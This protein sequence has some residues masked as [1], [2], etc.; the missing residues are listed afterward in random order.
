[1][2][3]WLVALVALVA[4]PAAAQEPTATMGVGGPSFC[5]NDL[6][7]VTT[8]RIEWCSDAA[9]VLNIYDTANPA[10]TPVATILWT[11]WTPE[12][13]PEGTPGG[14]CWSADVALDVET[15]IL[16]DACGE[17]PPPLC[18]PKEYIAQDCYIGDGTS[19]RVIPVGFTPDVVAVQ[20]ATGPGG[21]NRGQLVWVRGMDWAEISLSLGG[22]QVFSQTGILGPVADGFRVDNDLNVNEAGARY[23]WFAFAGAE[24]GF[25]AGRYIGSWQPE[26]PLPIDWK[27]DVV[28]II[29]QSTSGWLLSTITVDR[30]ELV[31]STAI[32]GGV[33]TT[34]AVPLVAFD[35]DG[36]R[37]QSCAVGAE[38]SSFYRPNVYGMEYW[39]FA[40]RAIPDAMSV[41]LT[42]G[43]SQARQG[44]PLGCTSKFFWLFRSHVGGGSGGCKLW[45]YQGITAD[46]F[47]C[48]F[49]GFTGAPPMGAA[50]SCTED[51]GL[52]YIES[53][54]QWVDM[55]GTGSNFGAGCNQ[56]GS[57]YTSVAF[58]DG[59][60]FVQ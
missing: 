29:P 52:R 39:W 40:L 48:S 44:H 31:G 1:M 20:H 30:P 47:G 37:I 3:R 2:I 13:T 38:C 54:Y 22:G 46:A 32:Q 33:S 41:Q 60:A 19:D 23:C 5:Y 57:Y 26:I 42:T 21:H 16:T 4:A 53:P 58:C 36:A 7:S 50:L 8:E 35:T 56:T 51:R 6:L 59:G 12:P 34:S 9:G 17:I 49:L 15:E 14:A 43:D 45:A 55:V 10:P 24:G 11:E 27:P 25:A 28:A 18:E